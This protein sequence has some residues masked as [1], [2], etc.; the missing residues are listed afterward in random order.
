MMMVSNFTKLLLISCVLIGAAIMV[1]AQV[2]QPV[3]IQLTPWP[4]VV[5]TGPEHSCLALN[6][7][8]FTVSSSINSAILNVAIQRYQSTLFFPFGNGTQTP[9]GAWSLVITVN[10]GDTSLTLETDESYSLSVKTTNTITLTANTIYGAIRGLETL[11]QTIQWV[12]SANTYQICYLPISIIDAPRFP[13]RGF[14]ID[15]GRHYY[16]ADFIL[17]IIDTLGYNK[18]NVLHW[19]IVDAQ[20]F[21]VESNTFPNLTMGAFNPVATYSHAEIQEIVAYAQSY[22][23]RV[24]PE[25]DVPAHADAIG[26]AFPHLI[27]NCPTYADDINSLLLNIANDYTYTFLNGLF[28]EMASLFP[29]HYFHTGGDEV[30]LDCWSED[31]TIQAWMKQH[32]YTTVQAEQYFETQVTD[33]LLQVNK[34]KLVWNDPWTNGV[35]LAEGT[36][37]EVWDN[38]EITQKIINEGF[39]ALVSFAWY[40]DEQMPSGVSVGE[41]ENTWQTFYKAD[42]YN[43]IKKNQQNILG[44]EA[45]MWSEQVNQ[46]NFDTRVY[47]RALAAAE[48]LWSPASI[49]DINN[50]QPRFDQRSCDMKIRGVASSPLQPS[51]CLLPPNNGMV[52]KARMGPV[53]RLTQSEIKAILTA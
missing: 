46:M 39:R 12:Q 17:H 16:P 45:C 9:S 35:K 51:F 8:L 4:E 18:F 6:P 19:H 53:H 5:G 11:S 3:G 10:S 2:I 29:D 34:T 22:G 14:L 20:S 36:V 15:T 13:W 38:S 52:T 27:A 25:F 33:M 31:P 30:H 24:V 26:T 23:I 1:G 40:L 7:H 44:G 49:T 47:P 21:G 42:P 48:R 50:A 28:T 37:I 41:F 43:G 32:K